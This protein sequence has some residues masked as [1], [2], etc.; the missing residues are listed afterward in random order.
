MPAYGSEFAA[1]LRRTTRRWFW[2]RCRESAGRPQRLYDF[3]RAYR[4]APKRTLAAGAD[5]GNGRPSH[6]GGVDSAG[7]RW[8][9][10]TAFFF[11]GEVAR[12]GIDDALRTY[13][14]TSR[15]GDRWASALHALMRTAYG[16]VRRNETEIAISLAYWAAAYLEM[17]APTGAPPRNAGSRP[18]SSPGS[19]PFR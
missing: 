14:P 6:L 3:F 11:A 10:R 1:D 12:L 19:R 2:W 17:P 7:A 15:S 8:S 16:L 13:L 4:D 5:A 18:I 9:R